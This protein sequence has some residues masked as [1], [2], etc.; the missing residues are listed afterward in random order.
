MSEG[1]HPKMRMSFPSALALGVAGN[2][3]VFELDLTESL[4]VQEIIKRLNQA[5][6]NGLQFLFAKEV[7][8]RR[9]RAVLFA[10][11]YEMALPENTVKQTEQKIQEFLSQTSFTVVK[12]NGISVD[13]RSVVEELAIIDDQTLRMK[14]TVTRGADA[15]FREVLEVLRLKDQLFRTIFPVRTHVLLCEEQNGN[16]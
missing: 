9:K 6:C 13:A 2:N 3:E 14:L 12:H 4:T 8:V 5:A 11:V 7:I 15:G 10:S 1:F 16:L